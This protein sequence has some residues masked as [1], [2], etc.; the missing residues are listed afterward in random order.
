VVARDKPSAAA[1]ARSRQEDEA[2]AAL[3]L[4]RG[5]RVRWRSGPGARWHGGA[6]RGRERDGSVAVTD[7]AG[8][9]RSLR[10][11][12]LEVRTTGR[13]GAPAW[14]A[15]TVRAA[16]AEQLCFDFSPA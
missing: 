7:D 4:A 6:V 11:E 3:G 9:L 12:R 8:A 15:V 16:R 2:L 10:V 14:E 1:A 5:D 13:R